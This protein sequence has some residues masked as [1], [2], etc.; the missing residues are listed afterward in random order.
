[1][2]SKAALQN[3]KDKAEEEEKNKVGEPLKLTYP[4]GLAGGP[5]K[6]KSN[7]NLHFQN[8]EESFSSFGGAKLDVKDRKETLTLTE[9]RSLIKQ[10]THFG[11]PPELN[12]NETSTNKVSKDAEITETLNTNRKIGDEEIKNAPVLLLE[13]LTGEVLKNNKLKINAAGLTTG[14]R[15]AKDGVAFFGKVKIIIFLTSFI[16]LF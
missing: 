2:N 8:V 10:G 3:N 6:G 7:K 14:L 4:N 16:I 15:K 9:K 11:K 5:A 13:E 12:D 1:M